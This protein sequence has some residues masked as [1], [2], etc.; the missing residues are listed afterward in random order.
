MG[1]D[2]G[3]EG[4]FF[5]D[6]IGVGAV[7]ELAARAIDRR[8]LLASLVL[9]AGVGSALRGIHEPS[10][11]M[12]AVA[13]G[14]VLVARGVLLGRPLRARH[15][16][17]AVAFLIA[18]TA[19]DLAGRDLVAWIATGLAGAVAV[20]PSGPPPSGGAEQRDRIWRLVERTQGDT[21]APFALRS[22][23]T[24]VFAP[25]GRAAVAYRVRFGTAVV[26]GDPVGALD[27]QAEALDAFFAHAAANGWR[28]AVL[29]VSERRIGLW[30]SRGYWALSVGREVLI[31]V[32]RFSL[33]GRRFRNLRQAVQ[34]TRNAGVRTEVVAE[35]DLDPGLRAELENVVRHARGGSQVRGFTMILDHLLDGT[36]PGT[37]ICLARDR[38]GRVVGF[39]RFASADRGRELSLDVPWRLPGSPNGIDERLAVDMVAWA[40]EHGAAR[41]S[42]AFA[43]F[44]DLFAIRHRT[45]LQRLAHWGVHR[46]DAV[47][48]LESLYR[49]LRKFHAMGQNRYVALRPRELLWVALAMLTLEFV[50][51]RT[52]ARRRRA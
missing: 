6:G 46:F 38:T 40:A 39:Q 5:A 27:S 29:G 13:A 12:L 44:P 8:Q 48:R 37:L 24:Y 25:D 1:P 14:G 11:D 49:F 21:L 28:T 19:A 17:I 3:D 4:G 52:I 31:D 10:H 16:L 15:A 34:R 9:L 51:H 42:L 32:P 43:P 18:G 45:G 23:K 22:D 41:L 50:P 26:S 20:L 30:R 36:H 47:I 33:L 35:A 7:R 2:K